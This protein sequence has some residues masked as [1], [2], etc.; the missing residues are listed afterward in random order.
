MTLCKAA[1]LPPDRKAVFK[2]RN[3]SFA[4]FRPPPG[5]TVFLGY[6]PQQKTIFGRVVLLFPGAFWGSVREL[7]STMEQSIPGEIIRFLAGSSPFLRP[8]E[9]KS[10]RG[11]RACCPTTTPL[12]LKIHRH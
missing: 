9:A 5:E 10:E 12:A 1:E 4:P 11:W 3:F 6:Y 8:T 2:P 7:F